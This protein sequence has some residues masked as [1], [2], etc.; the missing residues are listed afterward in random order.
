M[1]GLRDVPR[2]SSFKDLQLQTGAKAHIDTKGLSGGLATRPP[3]RPPDPENGSAGA[4]GTAS[5]AEVQSVLRRTTASYPEIVAHA[6]PTTPVRLRGPVGAAAATARR[7]PAPPRTAH[8]LAI[9]SRTAAGLR[10]SSGGSWRA[11]ASEGE[12]GEAA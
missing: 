6:N 11:E 1:V 9:P 12:A 3:D 7:A 10:S 5:G 8:R 2:H 4:V